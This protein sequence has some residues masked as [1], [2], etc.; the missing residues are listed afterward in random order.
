LICRFK[1][2]IQ[3]SGTGWIR[4]QP[5]YQF[6]AQVVIDGKPA[7][8]ADAQGRSALGRTE[9]DQ[10]QWGRSFEFVREC[11]PV[12]A[13]GADVIPFDSFPSRRSH[14]AATDFAVGKRCQYEYDPTLGAAGYYESQQFYDLCDELD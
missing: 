10:D 4:S 2:I 6:H 7:G 8:E 9:A 5:I 14:G 11:I 12:F 1:S 3:A 13:K